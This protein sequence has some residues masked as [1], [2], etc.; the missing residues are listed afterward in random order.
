MIYL[1][2]INQERKTGFYQYCQALPQIQLNFKITLRELKDYFNTTL[3]V[4][5]TRLLQ[6]MH[7]EYTIT[8]DRHFKTTPELV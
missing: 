7:K 3:S 5:H 4:L 6:G 8:F 1:K 2:G